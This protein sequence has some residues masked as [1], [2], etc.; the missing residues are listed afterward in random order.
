MITDEIEGNAVFCTIDFATRTF[1]VQNYCW[2][3]ISCLS[4]MTIWIKAKDFLSN[5]GWIKT[6][7]LSNDTFKIYSTLTND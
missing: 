7:I 3:G 2:D 5:I 4:N 6:P 1:K